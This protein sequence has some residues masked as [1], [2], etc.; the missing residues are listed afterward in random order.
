MDHEEWI[1]MNMFSACVQCFHHLG[2]LEFVALY[3]YYS[4]GIEY[5]DFYNKLL[6]FLE[7]RPETVAGD[8]FRRVREHFTSVINDGGPVVFVDEKY[9][10]VSWTAEEYAFLEIVREKKRFYDEIH[11][12]INSLGIDDSILTE[13]MNY[14]YAIVKVTAN[15]HDELIMQYDFPGYFANALSSSPV[16]L[17][18]KTLRL[19]INDP[20]TFDNWEDYARFV[21]WYGRRGGK[22]I[23]LSEAT[24]EPV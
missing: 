14:Q 17:S 5:G 24:C 20:D 10:L 15:P 1:R 9:G 18:K 4:Q 21:V 13:L 23:Y 2:L 22:N 7:E 19:V 6:S 3:C 11:E 8:V 12:F 16:P